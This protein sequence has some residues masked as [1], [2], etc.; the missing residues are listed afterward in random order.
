M[1]LRGIEDDYS[2]GLD[3]G[4][5]SVGWAV[6]DERGTLAHFK[7]KPTW[8]SRLFREA[9]TAAVARMPRGQRRRYVRRRWRLDLLQKL[10]EQQ[11]EQADPDFFIRLRQSRLLRD[12]RAEE[13]A[14]YRWPLFNDCKFTERDYYQRFPTIYHV[15]SWLMETDEQAD[16]RLIYLALHNIVKHRGNFLREGQSLSAK[17]ARPDEALNHLRETLR[18]WSSERGFECSIADNGSILAMLTHPDLSPSDRRKKIAPLFDVKSDDAAADKKLGIALAGAVIGLKTEFKNIFGDFPCEDSSIYLSNDEAVDAVRSAC[19]DDCA[20]LFDRLC[21]VYSA[22]VLQGL[23]SYAPGQTISANMVEKYRRYG[24]D[25]ALLKKL[26]KIYAPDQYRMFFSGATYPG[27]GI[28]DAAQ[29]RGYT[30]YNLGPKKSEYKPSESMQYDD[31]RKA[32]EKLFAKTDAR[33]DERYRMMMDRFDKQQF[34]RRLKTSDNGS[35]YHQLHLE[36][37]KA[38]VENQGRFYPFLKRDADKLVSLVSFRIPYYVGPL[39]TRNARTDQHGEN[40]FAWSERKPGMQDEPIFPWNWE[41]IIDRSKSAEKFIL[42]M[43]GMCTYLQQEPVL[44]KSSLL[45]EEFCVLN[46]LNGAHWSID[47]DDEHRFDAADREGIIEELFRRKRTVSYGDVAGWMERERNQIGAHV[48]GG[49]GEKGFES[50]LGSYIFFCKDVFKVERLEQS[51]YPMIERI[52]LWNTLFED[53]KILSQ[54]LKEEYGSRLSAE[55]IKTICKKRFTGWGRLSEKFLTGITVQVDEDS[56]SIM[57]VLREGCPVSG[58]RGRAMVMMEILRDEE[59][60]FQKKVDDFNRAFFAENAQ[61]LGVNEL[62]GSPAVRRSLNQSIRIVDEIASIA[63]KAPANIFIEV[64]RDEDPKKKGRRTKRR[65]NDLKDALEAF[66]KEDPELWRELCETAP[67]DMD[68]RLSLYFMQRGKCLYSGRAID[69]H[70]LSNAGIYEVDHIIPR[71]YVKDDS[72]ENKALVYREENQ[73]KTDMLL[74]DPEI[75]RRM[76]GYWRMLHEAKLIGDKKFRN[77]LRSRIDDKALKGFIARQLVETGQMV[78]LVRSL[79]E[80]RYPETN[81]ISVKASISHDLR[82]AAELVKCREANDFHH[83][84]DA[85]LACRVGLFIQKRHP[86]VYENPI[87]LSQVVRNYVRQQADIFKRCRTIPGSSGFIVNSFM[88]SGFDK[89]TGEIFKDD[90][91]AEAEVE[92]IRRSLNFRQCF[93]SRMPF[94]DHGVFWDA[95]IYSPRAKKTAA[96]P[97]K[98]GL[99]P[100][101]YGSF[102]REQFAY[103]FIYKARNP[104]K[105]QTLF[106]FAQVPVRLSAQIRQDEN[107][108]ERYARELAKDQGLEFIR[109]ERSKILKN[110]LIEIDGDRLCITGKEEVRNACELA[111]AQDEMR[112]IRMLVSEKPVSREC[113]ISL[114]NRILLHG[115]QASRRL[116]KQLKLALLSEAFS[117]A[118]DNVQRNVV[119]G[120]IAIFNGSTNMVNLSDIGGSKFAGNVRIKYKKELAS[121]KVNVHLIDQ[122]VTG[123]FERRTKIGL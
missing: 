45:Y 105:E 30:K 112:V 73:R 103:F 59:L 89:E 67:N 38:I 76:S 54:R 93:I 55:Q 81:I 20:E 114:F 24:E 82:T 120:L 58:K 117:E 75:R 35:I 77:L 11:M 19:P 122:S 98:Q 92:G 16:I 68:E 106:E 34:L 119:L 51:D 12:D 56:V 57:D 86:C 108:L 96:L 28:Y 104:R 100:S 47:G 3:M 113:V 18:V 53:R 29:A 50:K 115:D 43:T 39:S 85:F 60:G 78:K 42:R 31:F 25:L 95:T 40:R 2:I 17:S 9:Q 74:I 72:L 84:H 26:V 36:E 41:S 88:T 4:T 61:A 87:G 33:A 62:P 37:L 64:T 101:R 123:M 63:G 23:L 65:Y 49:Q 102:S 14:D 52:I 99:N 110:Q 94:E 69:I 107:A 22:Y 1:K 15:R 79:L 21:E 109:I 10:F 48:C 83:A 116:S 121:P 5:S 7:R 97:L 8:G 32:V 13:H 46:E 80:A 44:P 6:T 27:T 70:Q 118:S 66:K 71:T 91:D 90:W 111:F